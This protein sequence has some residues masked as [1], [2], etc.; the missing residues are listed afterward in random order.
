MNAT[1][2]KATECRAFSFALFMGQILVHDTAAPASSPAR[3]AGCREV[4]VINVE[5]E[6]ES[7]FIPLHVLPG[8]GL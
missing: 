1:K 3:G 7:R 4:S 8:H 5:E 2:K 6:E